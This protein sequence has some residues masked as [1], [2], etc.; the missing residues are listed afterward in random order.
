[1]RPTS[2]KY[3]SAARSI[4]ERSGKGAGN[5][6]FFPSGL[7]INETE[8]GDT[9]AFYPDNRTLFHYKKNSYFMFNGFSAQAEGTTAGIYD[10][11][12]GNSQRFHQ[13]EG[14]WEGCGDGHLMG[15]SNCARLGRQHVQPGLIVP[16]GGMREAYYWFSAAAGWKR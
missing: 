8:V 16:G 13:A 2:G 11:T 7:A 1:M 6:S 5:P 15:K 3:L 14:T 4:A 9:A 10:Y 12:T